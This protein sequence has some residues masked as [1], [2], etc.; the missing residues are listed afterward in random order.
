VKGKE[1]NWLRDCKAL[2]GLD[3]P[4]LMA[5]FPRTQVQRAQLAYRL[6]VAGLD[7]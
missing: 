7:G 4:V 3:D 5:A 2:L 1:R 6:L